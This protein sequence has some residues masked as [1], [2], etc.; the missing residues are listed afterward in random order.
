MDGREEVNA[1][2]GQQLA[3]LLHCEDF[4]LRN[5]DVLGDVDEELGFLEGFDLELLGHGR[6]DLC[7]ARWGEVSGSSKGRLSAEQR[8]LFAEGVMLVLKMMIPRLMFC[9]SRMVMNL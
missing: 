9:S 7:E 8:T 2:L 4:V 6:D 3:L 5:E 1:L